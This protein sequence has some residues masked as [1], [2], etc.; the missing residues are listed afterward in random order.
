M[1]DVALARGAQAVARGA[2]APANS[3]LAAPRATGRTVPPPSLH[4]PFT[5]RVRAAQ[6]PPT[7]FRSPSTGK[8]CRCSGRS[9]HTCLR[10]L[11]PARLRAM[12]PGQQP[13]RLRG[14]IGA[15]QPPWPPPAP[16]PPPPPAPPSPPPLPPPPA[17]PWGRRGPV[18]SSLCRCGET[19]CYAHVVF[20]SRLP[21]PGR[22]CADVARGP[23]Y[24]HFRTSRLQSP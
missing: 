20:A 24:G 22:C 19:T 14:P 10:E 13:V 17:P 2:S 7:R 21:S 18:R 5:R 8:A 23:G 3:C 4:S 15:R 12:W 11:P 9:K 6:A 16:P 1:R